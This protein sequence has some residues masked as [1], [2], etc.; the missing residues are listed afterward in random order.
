MVVLSGHQLACRKKDR[1]LFSQLDISVGQGQL[2]Y[3]RGPNGAG[4]TSLL[5]ILVGL[6]EAAEGQVF[7]HGQPL[8]D[9]RHEFHQALMFLGHKL[10]LN[11][12]L[13]AL[14]NLSFWCQQNGLQVSQETLYQRLALWGLVGLETIP[15][16]ELSA[17][18]Q[19]RVAL[20]RLGLKPDAQ[21]W[22]LDEPYTALDVDGIALLDAGILAHLQQGGAVIMTSHQPLSIEW[23]VEHLVLEYQI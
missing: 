10:G 6:S 9:A 11:R 7:F 17:G 21:L 14:E 12:T 16:S 23:T 5:R 18:Q 8:H 15:V 22:V 1:V 3:V 13:N 4:K 2:W 19:R 20:C